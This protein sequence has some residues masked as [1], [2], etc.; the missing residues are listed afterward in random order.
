VTPPQTAGAPAAGS[1]ASVCSRVGK[2]GSRPGGSVRA[3]SPD[4][5]PPSLPRRQPGATLPQR[6]RAAAGADQ[7]TEPA[8]TPHIPVPPEL[9]QQ[10]LDEL[11][12]L[13]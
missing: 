2:P 12:R 3:D 1:A 6:R 13:K 10:L 4:G 11:R 7:D 5:E 8:V 9:I